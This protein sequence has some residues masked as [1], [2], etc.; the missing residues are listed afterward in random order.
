M[1][2][3]RLETAFRARKR[4]TISN[5]NTVSPNLLFLLSRVTANRRKRTVIPE[6]TN[7]SLTML[8]ELL[9]WQR[10]QVDGYSQLWR[11]ASTGAALIMI[12]FI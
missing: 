4:P 6:D 5:N 1:Q 7:V 2:A 9:E 8:L 12:E 11:V 10:V 3:H